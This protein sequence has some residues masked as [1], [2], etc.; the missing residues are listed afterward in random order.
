MRAENS[1]VLLMLLVITVPAQAQWEQVPDK[2]VPRTESGEPDLTAD[3][4]R[5]ADG[6]PDLSGV[7]LADATLLPKDG[8]FELVEGDM[9]IPV[10]VMDVTAALEPGEVEMKPWAAKLLE[11]RLASQGLDDPIAYCKPW[12][13]TMHAANLLPYKIVQTPDLILILNEQDTVFRQIFLDGRKPVEDFHVGDRKH[14]LF[15]QN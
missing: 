1:A 10:Q 12:G 8:G 13:V 5:T 9:P 7:W 3:A 15:I 11:E 14:G 6:R 4:P 2:S